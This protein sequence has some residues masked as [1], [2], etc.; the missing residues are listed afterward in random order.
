MIQVCR[1][2]VALAEGVFGPF[3]NDIVELELP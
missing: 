3:E 1:D 2:C